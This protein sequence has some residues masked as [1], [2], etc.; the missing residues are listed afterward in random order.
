LSSNQ[1][2]II[3]SKG[4]RVGDDVQRYR[5]ENRQKDRDGADRKDP[6]NLGGAVNFAFRDTNTTMASR[7]DITVDPTATT[8]LLLVTIRLL[9]TLATAISQLDHF[10]VDHVESLLSQAQKENAS[11]PKTPIPAP[12][13]APASVPAK[14]KV[15]IQPV[16]SLN[17]LKVVPVSKPS[18]KL[19]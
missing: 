18:S 7:S 12:T 10:C 8:E 4:F 2:R 14:K 17:R 19:S 9:K 6:E 11:I 5:K 16:M 1:E 15:S 3:G 13:P